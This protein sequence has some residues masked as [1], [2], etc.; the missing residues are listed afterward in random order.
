MEASR[1][2]PGS[3][4]RRGR[5]R[6]SSANH[7]R[8]Q[9]DNT[10]AGRTIGKRNHGN[11]LEAGEHMR[12]L[13]DMDNCIAEFSEGIQSWIATHA[14]LPLAHRL[15]IKETPVS[16]WNMYR[17]DWNLKFS[18]FDSFVREA[19]RDYDFWF[20][21]N[22]VPGSLEGV[23]RIHEMGHE[24]HVVTNPWGEYDDECWRECSYQKMRWL[25]EYEIPVRSV[26]FGHEHKLD[27]DL[28]L[29]IDDHIVNVVE[30]A[31]T[32]RRAVCHSRLSNDPSLHS[33]TWTE[34]IGNRDEE[35]IMSRIVRLTWD[36]IPGYVRSF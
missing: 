16:D 4:N 23:R 24:I 14:D 30:F 7:Q 18:Q 1:Q 26:R 15:S 34:K 27:A 2:D 36:D 33:E 13:L 12:I 19:T 28:A 9:R 29:C 8:P 17:V 6:S 11:T 35:D 10:R 3:H 21:L 32:G 20:N 5:T 31:A 25:A 22:P